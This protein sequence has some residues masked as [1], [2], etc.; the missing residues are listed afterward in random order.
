MIC[1][2]CSRKL[3]LCICDDAED[4]IRKLVHPN[5]AIDVDAILAERFLNKFTIERDRKQ[6][7]G[8]K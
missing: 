4:R 2:I 1:T 6:Q 3:T 7:K 5:L 8:K